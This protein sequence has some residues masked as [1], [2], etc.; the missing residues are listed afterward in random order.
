MK[1]GRQKG[2]EAGIRGEEWEGTTGIQGS[3]NGAIP[4]EDECRT[5]QFMCSRTSGPATVG[6]NSR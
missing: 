3:S 6:R 2:I 4:P 5:G 1:G